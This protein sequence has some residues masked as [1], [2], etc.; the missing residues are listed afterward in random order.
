VPLY[1]LIRWYLALDAG[2]EIQACVD[3]HD[4][5]RYRYCT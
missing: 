2:R 1:R 3:L 5:A 4:D